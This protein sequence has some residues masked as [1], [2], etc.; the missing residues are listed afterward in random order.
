V[1]T[2]NSQTN[3]IQENLTA[4]LQALLADEKLRVEFV[5][6]VENNFFAWDQN[7]VGEGSLV[8]PELVLSPPDKGGWGGSADLSLAQ[9]TSQTNLSGGLGSEPVSN[10]GLKLESLGSLGIGTSLVQL[11][12]AADLGA[13]YLLAHNKKLHDQKNYERQEQKFFDEFEKIR[14]ISCVKNTYLGVVK[15]ILSKVESDIFSGSNSLSLILLKEIFGEQIL[16]R[17]A[18]FA[19]ELEENLNKKIVAEIKKLALVAEN[20]SDFALGVARV[21]ELLK[22]EQDLP[23]K[24]AEEEKSQEKP[25]K[26][27]PDEQ[28]NLGSETVETEVENNFSQGEEESE[29]Q[30]PVEQKTAD[31]KE[32]DSKG[33]L[34][35]KLDVTGFDEDQ[36]QFKN[37][38]KIFTNQF[39]EV[40]FPQKLIS[41]NELESL[42]DQLDLKMAKLS[43]VSR[44]MSLK[45]KRKLL[46]KKNSFSEVDSSRG[47]LDRKKLV[48]LV[49]NP[50][51]EDI[52][53]TNKTHEYQDTCL[54]ILLDNS[55]SM[56]GNPIV[57]AA[58]ACEI[59]AEI[60]EKFS[61][62]TEIIGFTTADWKGG[63]ARKLWERSGREGNP[64]RLNEL[65][66]IIYKHFN[67]SLK[68]SKTNLGLMLKEGILKENID[69]EALLFANSRLMQQ[70]EKRKILMVISDGTPVDDSTASSN[71]SDILSDHLRQVIKRI[72]QKAN[73]EI[74]GIGIG[75]SADDFY[76]NSL[77]IRSLEELG[78]GMIEKLAELL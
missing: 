6:E 39:D 23:E 49:T 50:L 77:T 70:N 8:L 43:G 20:Q 37:P 67:Q 48:R 22:N 40:I 13:C 78:D 12:A 46:S 61:V 38:Y 41:K 73:V 65:R 58:L 42:R 28:S 26:K 9:E 3:Q 52:W 51:S 18:E 33:N 14:V 60:L 25:S 64:G 74:V 68:K 21:L 17:T 66:H 75:H 54:T 10:L 44:K 2:K 76:R 11:R 34:S 57:V 63:R 24:K 19:A 35:L 15:N 32:D 56:R 45:L 72:G 1:K 27:S 7:L 53:I 30:A 59:I 47:I 69:G 62:K 71:D 55:G 36:I 5:G 29:T 16:P 4:T 31:F